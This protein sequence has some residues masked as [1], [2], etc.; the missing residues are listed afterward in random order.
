MPAG[1]ARAGS[2]QASRMN[3][4]TLGILPRLGFALV[5]WLTGELL[6]NRF[7]GC[8]GSESPLCIDYGR[9]ITPRTNP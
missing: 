2:R 9:P 8:F 5:P 3:L 4:S 7:S 6:D 1:P